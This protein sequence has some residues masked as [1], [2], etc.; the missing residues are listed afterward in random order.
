M[1]LSTA[2]ESAMLTSTFISRSKWASHFSRC[3][4]VEEKWNRE[5]VFGKVATVVNATVGH[6]EP[7]DSW[8]VFDAWVVKTGV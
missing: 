5:Q 8:L 7:V 2:D 6:N 1:R 4:D 3:T